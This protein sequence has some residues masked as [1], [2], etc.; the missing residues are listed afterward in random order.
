MPPRGTLALS[1]FLPAF[2][3]ATCL[4]RED[5][6]ARWRP[7]PGRGRD[8]NRLRC[9]LALSAG[10][11]GLSGQAAGRRSTWFYGGGVPTEG[12]QDGEGDR[13]KKDILG[14]RGAQLKQRQVWPEART[15]TGQ[16]RHEGEGERRQAV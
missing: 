2:T 1:R 10:Q 16:Q 15:G 13:R 7:G 6:E 4:W 11:L 5:A 8:V 9:L 12:G 14:G 3:Q